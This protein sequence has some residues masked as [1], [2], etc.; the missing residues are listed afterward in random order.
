MGQ[1]FVGI[2]GVSWKGW[3][4]DQGS[5]LLSGYRK[6]KLVKPGF[7][8]VLDVIQIANV[9]HVDH[10]VLLFAASSGGSIRVFGKKWLRGVASKY[11]SFP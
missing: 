4:E 9:C 3:N 8:A 11:G 10:F 6:S 5:S 1:T 7:S 2:Q